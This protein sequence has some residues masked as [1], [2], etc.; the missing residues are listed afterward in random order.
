[1]NR[2][3]RN[4]GIAGLAGLAALVVLVLAG[5]PIGPGPTGGVSAFSK[6]VITAKGSIFVNGV[7]FETTGATITVDDNAGAADADLLVGMVVSLKGTVDAATG[8]GNA[9]EILYAKNL[10]G[11]VDDKNVAAG[12][13]VVLGQTVQTDPTTVFEGT[14]DLASLSV[15]DR[16][17]V[18][19]TADAVANVIRAS[20][21]EVKSDSG[22]FDIK[23]TV[24]GSATGT[25]TLTSPGFTSSLTVNYTGTLAAGIVDGALVEVKFSSFSSLTI[26]TSADKV[27]LEDSL[28]PSD[29]ERTELSGVVS[30]LVTGGSGVTFTLDGFPVS[31]DNSLAAGIAN[32]MEVEVKGTL[33]AG[34]LVAD[35]LRAERESSSEIEGTLGPASVDTTAMTLTLN[36]VVVRVD[37]RTI[38]RDERSA[39]L[40]A[41]AL[42]DLIGGIHLKVQAYPDSSSA[43]AVAVATRVELTDPDSKVFI[44]SPV[45]TKETDQLTMLGVT[46][47]TSAASFLQPGG[48]PYADQA[49]FLAA[50]TLDTT[51]VKVKGTPVGST[52]T[53]TEAEVE[54]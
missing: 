13:F 31:A 52:L 2:A 23:G 22:D 28:E 6:G 5:C 40:A 36:G 42:S 54:D 3:K 49:A 33:S 11:I 47:D 27:S 20:R 35:E 25:F 37:S 18:S 10:E 44:K 26:T 29:G 16:V 17:E 12:T 21:V 39:P 51:I 53:A 14:A 50:I 38:F 7:E 41:P 4:R 32:G 46:V 30:G 45:S 24:S 15:D 9:T 1:M 19:G 43:P 48:A 34:V 8:R